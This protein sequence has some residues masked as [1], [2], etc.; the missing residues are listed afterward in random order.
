MKALTIYQPWATLIVH[1]FKYYETRSWQ[2]QVRGRIAIHAGRRV[3]K[4]AATLCEMEPFR[5]LLAR[6]GYGNFK[7]LPLGA[8]VGTAVLENCIP[9][10]GLEIESVERS[11]ADFRPGRW[12]WQL[13]QRQ[14]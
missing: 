4:D 12:A 5:S 3:L 8:V 1:G 9:A 2:T 11:L 13:T 7:S 6:A 14:P 10:N